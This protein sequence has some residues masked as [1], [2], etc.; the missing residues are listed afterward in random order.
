MDDHDEIISMR[1]QVGRLAA[2]ASSEKETRR[3]ENLRYHEDIR[4][5][6]RRID[7]ISKIVWTAI[8]GGSVIAFGLQFINK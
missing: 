2:D 6:H 1:A 5:L 4:D 7:F 8:G 3:R